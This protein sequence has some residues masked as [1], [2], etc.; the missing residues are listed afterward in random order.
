[1]FFAQLQDSVYLRRIFLFLGNRTEFLAHLAEKWGENAPKD[2]YQDAVGGAEYFQVPSSTHE[3]IT[4]RVYYLWTYT[5]NNTPRDIGTLAHESF[6]I[7]V[8]ILKDLMVETNDGNQGSESVAY[9]ME[10]ILTQSLTL[11]LEDA[12]RKQDI[13]EEA[14]AHV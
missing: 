3:G 8:T 12:K 1:M 9:Y 2:L 5:F 11:L 4:A 7:A 13:H 14:P 6:H 10:S